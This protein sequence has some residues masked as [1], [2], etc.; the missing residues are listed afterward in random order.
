MVPLQ[1]NLRS[2][3]V[4]RTTSVAT[5]AGIAMVVFVIAAAMMLVSGIQKT[6][7][8]AG[9]P[10]RAIVLRLG[11]VDELNS[12]F[13]SELVN[14][15][16]LKP[17]VRRDANDPI[18]VGESVTVGALD[19]VGAGGFS[20]VQF[21]GITAQ[22]IGF[23]PHL[24]VIAGTSPRP[25]TDEAMIG[26]R[27]RGRFKGL[28]M[29]E[30]FELR[31]NRPIRVVGVFDDAGSSYESEV[32]FDRNVLASAIGLE[33]SVN[34][35]RVQLA[36]EGEFDAFKTS[37]ETDK[38][39]HLS[40]MREMEFYERQS[41]GLTFLMSL[42]G[43][44]VSVFCAVGAMIGAMNTMYG[45]IANRRRE[46]G[47]LLALGFS[48]SLILL[49]FL[50]ESMLLTV[51][52]GA[53]GSLASLGMGTVSFSMMNQ[54]SWSEVVFR[55]EPTPRIL[56]VA[57]GAAALMGILG[58]LLPAVRAARISPTAAMRNA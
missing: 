32:W 24:K 6:L 10:D 7:S 3:I 33:G 41:E 52:G 46:I 31:K 28:S 26:A 1:Y 17:S 4:R 18:G 38:K 40:V 2:L 57:I 47:T 21:R 37:V 25:G 45:S 53:V 58:G 48:P 42:L 49:S 34:S 5:L 11:S 30:S 51:A 35:I 36:S 50:L 14:D 12:V 43:G 15:V 39:L 19:K 13:S 55:F 22:S 16:L 9:S 56:L 27:V 54:A 23:R 8:T 44:L 20:N 29:G